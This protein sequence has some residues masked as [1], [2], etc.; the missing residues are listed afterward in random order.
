MRLYHFCFASSL[1][2]FWFNYEQKSCNILW[3]HVVD[4]HHLCSSTGSW[5]C[6]SLC[7]LHSCVHTVAVDVFS[8]CPVNVSSSS[9]TSS[10]S[11]SFHPGDSWRGSGRIA[12]WHTTIWLL[13]TRLPP[14]FFLSLFVLVWVIQYIKLENSNYLILLRWNKIIIDV[15]K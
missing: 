15:I 13:Q 1:S 12:Q 11:P 8:F 14:S 6:Q 4:I 5:V 10:S 7:V 9:S 3:P 2:H